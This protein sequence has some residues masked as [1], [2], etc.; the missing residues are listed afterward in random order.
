MTKF[1]R[2]AHLVDE[3]P[4]REYVCRLDWS[5]RSPNLTRIEHAWDALGRKIT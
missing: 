2:K 4:E 5:V 3:F 1:G